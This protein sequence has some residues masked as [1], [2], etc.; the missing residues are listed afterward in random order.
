V[1][2]LRTSVE[3]QKGGNAYDWFFLAMAQWQL[4]RKD[5]ARTWFDKA[6]A[7]TRDHSPD[8]PQLRSFWD[9]A[10]SLIGR[11]GPGGAG[12]DGIPPRSP[13]PR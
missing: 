2:A 1:A 12:V 13:I 6:A 8:D 7:W 3:M 5:E 11:K 10:A 9:E 4:G